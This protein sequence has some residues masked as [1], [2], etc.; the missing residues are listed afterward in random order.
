[1]FSFLHNTNCFASYDLNTSINFV[2]LICFF[3]Y[4]SDISHASQLPGSTKNLLYYSTERK[5]SHLLLGW[6][7]GKYL[8][9]NLH[10]WEDYP[11]NVTAALELRRIWAAV[12]VY[13]A[14]RQE[15]EDW[16]A[17]NLLFWGNSSVWESGTDNKRIDDAR[18]VSGV[19]EQRFNKV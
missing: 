3:D 6:P 19:V 17:K 7:E 2:F 14:G 13:F 4:Q 12:C 16:A 9:A 18:V 10:F 5:K 15:G 1:M 8:T 11:F